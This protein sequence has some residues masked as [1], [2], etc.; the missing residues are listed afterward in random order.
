MISFKRRFTEVLAWLRTTRA[1]VCVSRLDHRAAQ[2]EGQWLGAAIAFYPLAT[3]F[4][5]R[6]EREGHLLAGRDMLLRVDEFAL[7]VLRHCNG[8]LAPREIKEAM[9]SHVRVAVAG[10]ECH[11]EALAEQVEEVLRVMSRYGVVVWIP[12]SHL[13]LHASTTRARLREMIR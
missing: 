12:C 11:D 9:A 7:T 6:Q 13:H 8:F 10:S 4:V 3:R 1:E 2:A 5:A